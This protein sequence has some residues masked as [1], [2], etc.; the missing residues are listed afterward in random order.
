MTTTEIR[1]AEIAEAL[2]DMAENGEPATPESIPAVLRDSIIASTESVSYAVQAVKG[3]RLSAE[4]AARYFATVYTQE[5]LGAFMDAFCA[6]APAT[7]SWDDDCES[8]AP[9]CCPWLTGAAGAA[10]GSTP[11]SLGRD[12]ALAVYEELE[13]L[14]ARDGTPTLSSKVAQ[15]V[16]YCLEHVGAVIPQYLE[17]DRD[18][19]CRACYSLSGVRERLP[20]DE[21]ERIISETIRETISLIIPRV[22]GRKNS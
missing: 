5:D 11:A 18:I 3:G 10:R 2:T 4:D 14:T 20:E 13:T 12:A 22:A 16:T 1:A 6:A 7:Y 21:A 17:P 19:I 15:D 9:W 8:S